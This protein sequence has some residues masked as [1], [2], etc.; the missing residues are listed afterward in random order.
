MRLPRTASLQEDVRRAESRGDAFKAEV[1]ALTQSGASDKAFVERAYKLVMAN[2]LKGKKIAVLF[3]GSTDGNLSSVKTALSD[4]GAG[5][6]IRFRALSVPIDQTKL[7][8]RL[9]NRPFLAAFAGP[10]Q[11]EQLGHA[12]GQEFASGGDTPLLNALQSL[13]V[14][15]KAGRTKKRA[16]GVV[17]VRTV[18]PQKGATAIFLKGLYAGL[19]DVGVPAVGVQGT[20]DVAS[21]MKAFQKAGLST[22]DDIDTRAGKLALATLL[23]D[24]TTRGD[25]GVKKTAKDGPLPDVPPVVTTTTGG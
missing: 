13:I 3:V 21:A 18:S 1:A 14:E 16:D 5:D 12:L 4:A 23:S 7:Q 10:K 15:E 19:N 25:F 8:Q 17:V 11:L 6:P 20:D 9:A 22:V 2:R 24:P